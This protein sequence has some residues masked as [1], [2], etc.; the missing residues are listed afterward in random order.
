MNCE[1]FENIVNDLARVKVIDAMARARVAHAE[2]CKRCAAR[3]ADE[4]ALTAGL[5]AL[6]ASDKRKAE[7]DSVEAALLMAF[8]AQVS[9]T[10][11]RRLPVQSWRWPRWC[12][13]KCRPGY[14]R[15]P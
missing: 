12:S 14:R 7:Q 9:K 1:N 10:S 6:S 13:R 4:R 15:S 2:T 3:L 8:R 11:A 5:R